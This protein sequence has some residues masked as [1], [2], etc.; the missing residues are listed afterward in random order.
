[1]TLSGSMRHSRPGLFSR[2]L[3]EERGRRVSSTLISHRS[4]GSAATAR[5]E[6]QAG[7]GATLATWHLRVPHTGRRGRI[8]RTLI[9]RAAIIFS[10]SFSL[11]WL[12]DGVARRLWQCGVAARVLRCAPHHTCSHPFSRRHASVLRRGL[13]LCYPPAP[14]LRH[15]SAGK[16][17]AR[18]C[19][20][21]PSISGFS[22]TGGVGDC[23]QSGRFSSSG[24]RDGS[25]RAAVLVRQWNRCTAPPVLVTS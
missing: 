22:A 18:R 23:G 19:M 12:S 17:F 7:T 1:M 5:R 15:F 9:S 4:G 8:G 24:G 14:C 20:P 25:E 16:L 3:R 10:V 13:S 11:G 2:T 21:L 6:R